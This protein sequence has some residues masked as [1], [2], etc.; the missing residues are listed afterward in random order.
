[1]ESQAPVK[2]SETRKEVPANDFNI[3]SV[4]DLVKNAVVS[5]KWKEIEEL[6]QIQKQIDE[7][8]RQLKIMPGEPIEAPKATTPEQEDDEEEDFLNLKADDMDD[9]DNNSQPK[10]TTGKESSTSSNSLSHRRNRSPIVFERAR[11][12]HSPDNSRERESRPERAS[13]KNGSAGRAEN[14][15]SLSAHRQMERELYTPVHRR[16]DE[17]VNTSSGAQAP[18]RRPRNPSPERDS[19]RHRQPEP[20]DHRNSSGA[21]DR[22]RNSVHHRQRSPHRRDRREAS[23]LRESRRPFRERERERATPPPTPAHQ[24]SSRATRTE[25]VRT[26]KEHVAAV[27]VR[28]RIGSRV[29]V[30][31][32][33]LVEEEE[34]VD[35]PVSS[36]VTIK[37]RPVVAKNRQAN[38]NLLLRAMADAQKSMVGTLPKPLEAPVAA[39]MRLSARAEGS[40]GGG[41]KDRLGGITNRV[42]SKR[43][44]SQINAI[45]SSL[46]PMLKR[47]KPN[48]KIIIEIGPNDGFSESDEDE[49]ELEVQGKQQ[50]GNNGL[51]NAEE[52]EYVPKPVDM[53]SKEA[54]TG[55]IVAV[56]EEEED[57]AEAID[58]SDSNTQFVVTLDGA[59]KKTAQAAARKRM[60]V[61]Q[62]REVLLETVKKVP[63]RTEVG[64]RSRLSARSAA[65]EVVEERRQEVREERGPR[66]LVDLRQRVQEKRNESPGQRRQGGRGEPPATSPTAM[67]RKRRSPIKFSE[68]RQDNGGEPQNRESEKVVIAAAPQRKRIRITDSPQNEDSATPAAANG[69][70]PKATSVVGLSKEKRDPKKYDN[71]PPRKLLAYK[72]ALNE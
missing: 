66:K 39:T 11:A 59:F 67:N 25:V 10:G 40:G 41:I 42:A 64:I 34:E 33:K 70:D 32:P 31:P 63:V 18:I 35:V 16:R 50:N 14:I 8:K 21:A 17:N 49:G 30:A 27:P 43:Q 71:I 3:P 20:Q 55:L 5:S 57:K 37:P 38:K 48:E 69:D 15:I 2:K 45:V 29:I 60:D 68:N 54:E 23:P 28:Q 44:R 52:V 62:R 61:A 19:R 22:D 9:E 58:E 53:R 51:T 26:A 65:T 72:C 4:T 24:L 7:A 46:D 56:A 1:M 6:E 36:V 12:R 47:Q 13:G